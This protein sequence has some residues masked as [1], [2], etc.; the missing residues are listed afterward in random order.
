MWANSVLKWA[1]QTLETVD[2]STAGASKK[3]TT[4]GKSDDD[5]ESRI[6]SSVHED[7]S[8]NVDHYKSSE[9][10]TAFVTANHTAL[11][12]TTNSVA[13]ENVN[14]DKIREEAEEELM[15]EFFKKS[16]SERLE[17]ALQF[18]KDCANSSI[19]GETTVQVEGDETLK[20]NQEIS[21]EKS[22]VTLYDQVKKVEYFN[23]NLKE[24]FDKLTSQSKHSQ[25]YNAESQNVSTSGNSMNI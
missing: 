1:E 20:Q 22:I 18:V 10:G 19:I 11:T 7:E 6:D 17:E 16:E 24:H 23:K 13:V 2:R 4:L 8:K 15:N 5:S 25:R 12:S 3:L 9:E 14:F 21:N